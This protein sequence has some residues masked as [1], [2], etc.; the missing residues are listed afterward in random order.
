[1]A[2]ALVQIVPIAAFEM[3]IATSNLSVAT[4]A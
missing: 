2:M 3:L 1:M 4:T